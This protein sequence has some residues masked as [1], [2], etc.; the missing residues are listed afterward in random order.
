M[1]LKKN[2]PYLVIFGIGVTLLA[3]INYKYNSD[4]AQIRALY[5]AEIHQE[6]ERVAKRVEDAFRD[7]YQGLRTMTIMDPENWTA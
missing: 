2:L 7:F 4:M 1:N 3:F 6:T 5:V